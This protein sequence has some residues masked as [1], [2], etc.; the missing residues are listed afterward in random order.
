M[1][2]KTRTLRMDDNEPWWRRFLD[3]TRLKWGKLV[4]DD[5]RLAAD[6][7]ECLTAKFKELYDMPE[8]EA[9]NA[10]R[11]VQLQ[12]QQAAWGAELTP[13]DDDYETQ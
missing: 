3:S 10:A 5:I 13:Q 12:L 4:D 8:D 6:N 9:M 2:E 11:D 1:M 7:V